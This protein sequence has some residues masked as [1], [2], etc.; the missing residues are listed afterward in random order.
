MNKYIDTYMHAYMHTYITSHHITS[1]H[2][3]SHHIH[4]HISIHNYP[5]SYNNF[6]VKVTIS[7]N[8]QGHFPHSCFYLVSSSEAS[9]SS[10]FPS[11]VL[12]FPSDIAMFTHFP[13]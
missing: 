10:S 8:S 6:P 11:K 13:L 2:I 5:S 4:T 3:A 12:K 9:S 7:V 1:H